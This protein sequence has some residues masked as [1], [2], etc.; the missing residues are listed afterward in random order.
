MPHNKIRANVAVADQAIAPFF[1]RRV[2]LFIEQHAGDN[3]ALA[4]LAGVT[5]CPRAHCK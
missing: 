5:G 3:I 4:D 1:V 2:E